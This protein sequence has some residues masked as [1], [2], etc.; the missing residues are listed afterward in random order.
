MKHLKSLLIAAA[1]LV[2]IAAPALAADMRM[3]VK[4]PAPVATP[5]A[6]WTG[7]Y[8]GIN[9]GGAWGTTR[10]TDSTTGLTTNNYSQSGGLIGGTYG[11]NWQTGM[12]VLGFEGD[13]DWANINGNFTNA[14]LCGVNNGNTCFT[15]LQDFGT[16]RIRVGVDVSGWLLYGTGGVAY[17]EVNAGQTPCGGVFV[18]GCGQK[19]RSGWVAGGGVEKMFAP[20]WSAKLEYLHFDFGNDV[21]YRPVVNVNVLERGDIV[22]GGI[23]YLF[24][25]FP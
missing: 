3:P 11:A 1:G 4:A 13:F 6:T 19:W 9:G 10:H 25:P 16:D 7:L 23:N 2:T 18:G 14:G 22:R 24:N 21:Q 15:K 8:L 12:F 5:V 20:H 17:G